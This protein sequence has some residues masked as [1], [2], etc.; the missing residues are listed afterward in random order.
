[1]GNCALGLCLG[2]VA[3]CFCPSSLPCHHLQETKAASSCTAGYNLRKGG[4]GPEHTC[5]LQG[6]R[7][8]QVSLKED[9]SSSQHSDELLLT[10]REC[11]AWGWGCGMERSDIP[12]LG[13]NE[14]GKSISFTLDLEK[15]QG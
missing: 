2:S 14:R 13:K 1:M 9:F 5:F 12:G 6:W 8:I 10:R 15:V 11:R 3:P 7:K 4:R